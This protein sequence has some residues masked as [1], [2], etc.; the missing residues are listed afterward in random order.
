VGSAAALGLAAGRA[1]EVR[2]RGGHQVGGGEEERVVGLARLLLHS[3]HPDGIRLERDGGPGVSAIGRH[4]RASHGGESLAR[5]HAR[6]ADV[7]GGRQQGAPLAGLTAVFTSIAEHAGTQL[8]TGS[9]F[10]TAPLP[11]NVTCN[12]VKG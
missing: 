11:C 10:A 3:L 1:R 7:T 2:E 8:P 12:A 4:W 9:K 6:G 5:A